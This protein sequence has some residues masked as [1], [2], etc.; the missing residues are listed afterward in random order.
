VTADQAAPAEVRDL[1]A[2]AMLDG[3]GVGAA[4]P[5]AKERP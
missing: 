5:D 1:P 4:P 3:R 2:T